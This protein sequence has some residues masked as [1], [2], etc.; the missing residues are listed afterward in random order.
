[1]HPAP[2]IILFTVGSGAGFGL[3]FWLGLG[4]PVL[5][6]WEALGIFAL[7]YLLAAG[8]LAA[9]AFHL[10]NPQRALLAFTQWRTSWLSREA[11]LS[12]LCLLVMALYGAGLVIY[13]AFWWPVGFLGAT[14]ALATVGATSMIYAQ[15]RSV[16]RW[17]HWSTPAMF[18]GYALT[19]GALLS[20]QPQ[21]AA[22]ALVLTGLAQAWVWW[23]GDTLFA[24]AGHSIETAT[25]LGGLG[26]VRQLE[27]PH[28]SDNYLLREMV[29]V[30]GR[31]H[32][33]KLRGIALTLGF[34]L[35]LALI[36]V[37]GSGPLVFGIAAA[38]H[39]GG[40]L[41]ARW[42]FFAQAEHVVGLYYGRR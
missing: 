10:G 32:A 15:L 7:A 27:P 14:L 9:S 41:V 13:H 8:G 17:R 38:A 21:A 29:H 33:A 22:A 30:V 36:L 20:G 24:E 6:G 12:L 37:A 16:P 31:R 39:L 42:L 35:P 40:A 3:L 23:R 18:L 2:S 19:G 25:G 26:K 11:W 4:Q 28:T 5:A 34:V 1:M